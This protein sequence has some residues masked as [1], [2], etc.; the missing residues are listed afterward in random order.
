MRAPGTVKDVAYYIGTDVGGT[1]TDCVVLTDDG[2]TVMHK[3]PS[4][5]PR[6]HEGLFRCLDGAA[7]QL[8]CTVLELLARTRL[9]AH[10]C[11]VATNALI[12]RSGARVGLLTTLGFEE[13]LMLMRGSAYCQGLPV[14]AWYRKTQ[15]ERPFELL[16]Q[17]RVIGIAERIDRDGAEVV[18]LDE[19]AVMQA[20]RF[21]LQEEHC[22]AL[23][24]VFLWACVNPRHEDRAR[25]LIL[26]Q[27]PHACITTSSDVLPLIGEYERTSTTVLNS[28][29]RPEVERYVTA[30]GNALEGEGLR[31][32]VYL[33][34]GNGGVVPAAEAAARA[35]TVLQSGP[36]GGVLAAQIVGRLLGSDK[37]IT[38][39]M[40][41]TSFD[42][43]LIVD[44]T[45]Q[46]RKRSCHQRHV[47]AAPMVDV[48]SI[49]AGGGSIAAVHDGR[50]TVGPQSAGAQ[51]GPVCYRLGGT[52]PTVTD[53]N[54]VLGYVNPDFFLGGALQLDPGAAA[55]AI[56]RLVAEP[57]GCSVH[58]AAAGIHRIVNA[59]M[60]DAIRYHVL[61]RGY[62]PRDFDL[63]L[64]GGATGVHAVGIGTELNVR[65][66]VVPLAGL[67]P[68]LSAFGIANSDVLRV[69]V[70][71]Q[72]SPF[73]PED[74]GAPNRTYDQLEAQARAEL[75]S[76]GF[77]PAD[78]QVE[79][80]ASL[81]YHLQLTEVDIPL[82]P[83][84]IDAATAQE[85]V[86]RFDSRYAQ[87][88]GEGAG[89]KDAGRD[90]ITQMVKVKGRT[91]KGRL[92][93]TPLDR[94][95]PRHALKGAR[96]VYFPAA[97]LVD[98]ALY[99]GDTLR[100]GNVV[101]GPALLEMLSTTVLVPAGY[102][103]RY[104]AYRNIQLCE[105]QP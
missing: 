13:T 81:R 42:I 20:A 59:H 55:D 82:P 90:L 61:S 68:A 96:P 73:P 50:I 38:G 35:A 43:S 85:I 14:E 60:A 80:W 24:I 27:Y 8:R 53:A 9:F 11:T 105:A 88:Y 100:A 26:T 93:A 91:P 58:E 69:A 34:Q 18:R 97:G 4:T 2:R 40:G 104:D 15:N 32:P 65:S 21:L 22:E 77:A 45:V 48:E 66:I 47:V 30:M 72:S 19:A 74:L 76:Q 87:L 16:P 54:V 67:A 41:G 89:F 102:Q 25:D 75:E 98:A 46:Y 12:N 10:G 62:D 95:D 99:D 37:I 78:V 84:P 28:Y 79:R 52:Q 57:L 70:A 51:P 3:T 33:M 86:Q 23:S 1:F 64:F 94:A 83:G 44:G 29:L 17:R 101:T 39:D 36:T 71:S 31:V 7:A 5:P 92:E 6:F 56:G 103:A 63:Y 49:G